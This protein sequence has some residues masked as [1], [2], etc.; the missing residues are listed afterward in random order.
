MATKTKRQ[1][2]YSEIESTIHVN[3]GD[4][5]TLSDGTIHQ[6]HSSRV[7]LPGE[8]ISLDEVPS[9]MVELVKEKKAPGLLLLDE[10]EADKLN[11]F[12]KLIRGEGKVSDLIEVPAPEL[13]GPLV[14]S[15][16]TL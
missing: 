16:I 12:A 10:A 15:E 4:A 5:E 14:S 3:E 13:P 9:Y 8:T 7:L 11:E 1:V 6:A 2:I